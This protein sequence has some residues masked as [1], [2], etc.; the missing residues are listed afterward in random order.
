MSRAGCISAAACWPS[1]DEH[2]RRR[3][4]LL[5]EA[6]R[7]APIRPSS[8]CCG[9][10]SAASFG[11]TRT[12]RRTS[13][14]S[15]G[16]TRRTRR[17]TSS[18]AGCCGARGWSASAATHFP[19]RARV[20]AGQRPGLL[21]PGRRVEPGGRPRRARVR[22]SSAPS[23]STLATRRPTICSAGCS[24]GSATPTRL[25][26][27]TSVPG[28]SPARDPGGRRRSG[29]G[30]GGRG[31]PAGGCDLAPVGPAAVRLDELGGERFAAQRRTRRRSRPAPRW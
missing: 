3:S 7:H 13:G 26:R 23:S 9:A 8:W 30:S 6:L 28:S 15:S 29:A 10:G 25:V 12:R 24:T 4:R 17:R 5:T 22:R 2:R 31:A 19:P 20:P 11:G 14:A 16:C 27:C 1:L 18:S 21:L